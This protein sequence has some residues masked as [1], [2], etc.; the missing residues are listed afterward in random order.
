VTGREQE[1]RR[2]DSERQVLWPDQ[3]EAV[4]EQWVPPARRRLQE[5]VLLELRWEPVK[6]RT[7]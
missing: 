5:R 4:L 2:D 3:T 6:P 1:L 7:A